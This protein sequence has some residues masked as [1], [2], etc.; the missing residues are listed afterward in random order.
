VL[1]SVLEVV[2]GDVHAATSFLQAD[3]GGYAFNPQQESNIP[4]DYPGQSVLMI[5][6]ICFLFCFF[7]FLQL[8]ANGGIEICGVWTKKN[9]A[10][11]C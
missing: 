10:R 2:N 4:S 1:A 6:V 11:F 9:R 3:A 5:L 7:G 8:R